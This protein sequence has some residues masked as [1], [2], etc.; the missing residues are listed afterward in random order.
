MV[1]METRFSGS[2]IGQCLG[3]A[4]GFPVEGHSPDICRLCVDVL[5][6]GRLEALMHEGH[7]FGQ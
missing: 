4:A 1:P 6:A 5:R 2:L 7:E 3:D